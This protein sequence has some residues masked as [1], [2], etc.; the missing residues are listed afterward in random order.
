MS[1]GRPRQAHFT[2]INSGTAVVDTTTK[3][4]VTDMSTYTNTYYYSAFGFD[5]G[6]DYFAYGPGF[7]SI[8]DGTYVDNLGNTRT[9]DSCYFVDGE[10][11]PAAM[12]WVY[13]VLDGISIPNNN[14]TF[15][16][17][18]IDGTEF[19]RS[20]AGYLSS[21]D[22]GTGWEWGFDPNLPTGNPFSGTN[23]DDF[24]VWVSR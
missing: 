20:D 18:I 2:T 1:G 4:I 15:Y 13:F 24:E 3:E 6:S 23:P 11:E 16:S 7:G 8:S 10:H 17:I 22:G 21:V 12:D 19:L 14:N 9:I 5:A